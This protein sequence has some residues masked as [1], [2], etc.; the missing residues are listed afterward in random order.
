MPRR[1]RKREGGR[2][3]KGERE[4]RERTARGEGDGFLLKND[5]YSSLYTQNTD[6]VHLR[7]QTVS[8]LSYI[9]GEGLR[10]VLTVVLR[11]LAVCGV[12]SER[13]REGGGG[14]G[15]RGAEGGGRVGGRE[16]GREGGGRMG[17]GGGEDKE[18]ECL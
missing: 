4:E 8:I 11:S 2:E 6:D 3:R 9:S 1:E 13:D 14:V 12:C 5:A 16:G 7:Y 17:R 10:S 15:G 18:E